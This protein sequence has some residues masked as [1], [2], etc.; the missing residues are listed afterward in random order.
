M[1]PLDGGLPPEELPPVESGGPPPEPRSLGAGVVGSHA[2][3]PCRTKRGA[4]QRV[5]ALERRR[6]ELEM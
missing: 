6:T 1:P 3:R 4:N 2:P 5:V